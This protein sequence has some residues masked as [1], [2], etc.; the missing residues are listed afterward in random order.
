MKKIYL[1]L[2]AVTL[3]FAACNNAPEGDTAE[4]AKEETVALET[5]AGEAYAIAEGSKVSFYGATP[6]HGQNGDL[7]LES[8]SLYVSDGKI[9]GG[10]VSV[11]L[12]NM[13]ITSE[14]LE[15]EKKS[16]LKEH[17]LGA[18]FFDAAANPKIK[19]EITGAEVLEGDASNTHT[20]S[21]NLTMH[22]KTN[23]ISFPAK[24]TL[25]EGRVKAAADF[26]VNRK[27]WDMSYKNDE[28]LGDKWI[29]DEIK[30]NF[31]ITATK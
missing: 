24:V 5:P 29:Y 15:E 6:T 8:G 26:I 17:L 11:K 7:P 25:E 19:F 3:M 1:S 22:G 4:V 10:S 12:D 16:D 21:G 30:L 2:L 14:G 9:T 27:E 31:D 28:S 13:V 20:V 23:N 18:D